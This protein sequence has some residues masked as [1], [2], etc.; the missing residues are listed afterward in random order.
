MDNVQSVRFLDGRRSVFVGVLSALSVLVLVLYLALPGGSN[1]SFAAGYKAGSGIEGVVQDEDGGS[2]ADAKVTATFLRNGKVLKTVKATLR[3]DGTFRI[4]APKRATAVTV[5][6][7]RGSRKGSKRFALRR[8]TTLKL[9][10]TVPNRGGVL[11]N[12]LPAFPF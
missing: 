10:V 1:V 11:V 8:G 5:A 6:A 9:T 2:L 3:K 12:L 4:S 7:A